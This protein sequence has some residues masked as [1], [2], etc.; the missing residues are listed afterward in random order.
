VYI[1]TIN[2]FF[3]FKLRRYQT[4]LGVKTWLDLSDITLC[5]CYETPLLRSFYLEYSQHLSYQQ[6]ALLV[7]QRVS[8]GSLSDQHICHQV[9]AYAREIATQQARS[10]AEWQAMGSVCQAEPVCIYEADAPETL[11]FSD[12]VCVGE[13]KA[14]RDKKAKEG[15]ERSN[16]NVLLLQVRPKAKESSP[17]FETLIAGEGICEVSLVQSMVHQHYGSLGIGL[18]VVAITDGATCLKNQAKAI[19]GQ[20][21]THILD[22]YHLQ[23]KVRQLMSQIAPNKAVKEEMIKMLLHYLWQ[24][25][26]VTATLALKFLVPKNKDKQKELIGYL[27]KNE[28]YIIDYERRKKAGKVIGSG[29]VEKQNDLIVA[30]RQKR[31]GMAWSPKGSRNLAILTAYHKNKANTRT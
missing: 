14:R 15:K 6:T 31:K 29:R 18:P 20:H 3:P 4:D 9:A 12:G 7:S 19:F 28:G 1:K 25:K 23:S 2:G 5:G 10:I 27:E 24:G 13:Q 8:K 26:V 21:L 30:K 22:W 17:V 11:F 16:I